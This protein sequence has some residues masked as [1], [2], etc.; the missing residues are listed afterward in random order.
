MLDSWF[1][2]VARRCNLYHMSTLRVGSNVF[3]LIKLLLLLVVQLLLAWRVI[4]L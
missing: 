3:L 1:I 4:I 2:F